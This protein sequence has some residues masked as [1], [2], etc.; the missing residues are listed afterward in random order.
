[1]NLIELNSYSVINKGTLLK[2]MNFPVL[3][4]IPL[5]EGGIYLV[6]DRAACNFDVVMR[7]HLIRIKLEKIRWGER[8]I[9]VEGNIWGEE[10]RGNWFKYHFREIEETP[11]ELLEPQTILSAG[12]LLRINKIEGVLCGE[13]EL[14]DLFILASNIRLIEDDLCLLKVRPLKDL[15]KYY[16]LSQERFSYFG[17]GRSSDVSFYSGLNRMKIAKRKLDKIRKISI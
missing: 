7:L 14:G 5:H 3:G 9:R 1:M 10:I 2:C 8:G 11:L 15:S 12:S 17:I 16:R 13:I 6:C 4:E